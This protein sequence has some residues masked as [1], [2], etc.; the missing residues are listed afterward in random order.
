MSRAASYAAMFD[1]AGRR[2]TIERKSNGET[3]TVPNVRARVRG[4]REEEIAGGIQASER[5]VLILAADVPE[6]LRPLL[7]NDSILVDGLRLRIQG[8]PDDQTHRDGETLLAIDC[9]VKGA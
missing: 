4:A 1:R 6:A 8:R 7:A 2:V 5:K 9:V 3:T